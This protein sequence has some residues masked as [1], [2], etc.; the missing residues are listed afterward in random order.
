MTKII[1][2]IELDEELNEGEYNGIKHSILFYKGSKPVADDRREAI[3]TEYRELL[4]RAKTITQHQSGWVMMIDFATLDDSK[5]AH[6]LN[7]EMFITSSVHPS[8]IAQALEAIFT[9]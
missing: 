1:V 4:S 8:Q 9:Y 3:R 7:D 6:D 2:T 5:R